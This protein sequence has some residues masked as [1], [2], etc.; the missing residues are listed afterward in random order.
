[1]TDLKPDMRTQQRLHYSPLPHLGRIWFSALGWVVSAAPLSLDAM[2]GR[3]RGQSPVPGRSGAPKAALAV[4]A[5]TSLSALAQF[6]AA[7][8]ASPFPSPGFLRRVD[9]LALRGPSFRPSPHAR[10]FASGRLTVTQLQ[11]PR[12]NLPPPPC[13]QNRIAEVADSGRIGRCSH[14]SLQGKLA[15]ASVDA[16]D[17]ERCGISSWHH[18]SWLH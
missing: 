16:G 9:R 7:Q 1:M 18:L 10:C 15:D 3:R 5:K 4:R 17:G 13:P 14:R 6:V 11:P 8:R 2:L 12:K